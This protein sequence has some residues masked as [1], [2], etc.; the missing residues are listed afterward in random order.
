MLANTLQNKMLFYK[1]FLFGPVSGIICPRFV[2]IFNMFDV[3]TFIDRYT[4]EIFLIIGVVFVMLMSTM[5]LLILRSGKQTKISHKQ[6]EFINQVL[7]NAHEY[8]KESIEDNPENGEQK[9]KKEDL[10]D[11]FIDLIH[12]QESIPKHK[13]G[14]ASSKPESY[15]TKFQKSLE[16][17][18]EEQDAQL[19]RKNKKLKEMWERINIGRT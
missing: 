9:E 4:F 12:T 10:R 1:S 3:Q 11:S 5:V 14:T 18:K 6:K 13:K 16:V 19:R 17:S 2:T 8:E 15:K 7:Q